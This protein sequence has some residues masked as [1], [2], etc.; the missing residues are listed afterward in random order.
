MFWIFI[1]PIIVILYRFKRLRII[2]WFRPSILIT[3]YISLNLL[4]GVIILENDLLFYNRY[5]DIV[6]HPSYHLSLFLLLTLL[7]SSTLVIPVRPLIIGYQSFSTSVYWI[8]LS[9]IIC[10]IMVPINLPLLGLKGS[11]SIYLLMALYPML[12]L[13]V[14]SLRIY[15]LIS[16]FVLVLASQS[17]FDNKREVI[18]IVIMAIGILGLRFFEFKLRHVVTFAISGVFL[19]LY[20]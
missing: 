15:L 7:L 8:M 19:V 16:V 2:D 10:I 4:F 17:F 13:S 18:F 12:L 1:I 14:K 11:I 20:L 6:S 9:C 5:D 3:I